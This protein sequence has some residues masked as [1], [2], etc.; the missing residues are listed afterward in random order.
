M[1]MTRSEQATATRALSVCRQSCVTALPQRMLPFN[2]RL[3]KSQTCAQRSGT[4]NNQ[5]SFYPDNLNAVT[6]LHV[7]P[8]D[9]QK[10]LQHSCDSKMFDK[11]GGARALCSETRDEAPYPQCT[12]CAGSHHQSVARIR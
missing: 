1:R 12:V 4:R 6:V 10:R 8:F 3:E 11:R 9:Q 5:A 2:R 7:V